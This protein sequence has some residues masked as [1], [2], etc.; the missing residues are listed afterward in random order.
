MYR[1]NKEQHQ[2]M[3]DSISFIER[4]GSWLKSD[5]EYNEIEKVLD[6]FVSLG[7]QSK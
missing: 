6:D 2:F 5:K 4:S 3:E 7:S 1:S